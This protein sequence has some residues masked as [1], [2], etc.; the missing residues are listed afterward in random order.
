MSDF[1]DLISN[2]G[3]PEAREI[4]VRGE[5]GTVYFRRMSAGQREQLLKGMKVSHTPGTKKGTI[6]VDLSQNERQRQMMV[7]F[8]VCD[9]E[10]TARYKR[11]EDVAKLP[12]DVVTALAREAESIDHE[13]DEEDDEGKDSA[14]SQD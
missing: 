9:E 3:A 7:L 5:T 13:L 4:T 8:C 2:F 11:I 14:D 12:S 10:G 6:D 1:L